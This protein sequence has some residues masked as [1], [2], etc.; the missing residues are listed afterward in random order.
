MPEPTIN[1]L[2]EPATP[3][4]KQITKAE[5][6]VEPTAEQLH[7]AKPEALQEDRVTK[8]EKM[9]ESTEKLGELEAPNWK[10]RSM[11]TE[12]EALKDDWI[13]KAEDMAEPAAEQLANLEAMEE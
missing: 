9:P 4:E 12:P 11:L 6:T 3:K 5:K 1:K 7:V 10:P 13:A 2:S 8:A